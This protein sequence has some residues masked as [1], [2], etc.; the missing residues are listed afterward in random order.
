MP[1]VNTPSIVKLRIVPI[2]LFASRTSAFD[3]AAVPGVIPSKTLSS[4]ALVVTATPARD[5]PPIIFT[6]PA[7]HLELMLQLQ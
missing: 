7:P 5:K 1:S 4:E 3:A 2:S 6:P